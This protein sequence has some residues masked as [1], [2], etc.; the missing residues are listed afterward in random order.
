M[1]TAG[2]GLPYVPGRATVTMSPRFISCLAYP[3][4][5]LARIAG[6]RKS[7]AATPDIDLKDVE[8]EVALAAI[9]E[10]VYALGGE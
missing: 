6:R 2:P 9:V 5:A 10:A 8:I 7:E 4:A 3:D 1:I